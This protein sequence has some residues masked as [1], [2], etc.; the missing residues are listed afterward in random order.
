MIRYK[1][2]RHKQEKKHEKWAARKRERDEQLT[3][4][5]EV[6]PEEPDP[7]AEAEIGLWGLV[8]FLLSTIAIVMLTGKFVTGSYI[9]E[10]DG[11]WVQAKTYSQ[12]RNVTPRHAPLLHHTRGIAKTCL[13]L[14]G[15]VRPIG[16]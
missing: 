6:G 15:P 11:K 5:E 10:Y 13:F 7:T 4:G 16:H 2:Y 9:W 14:A 8:K 12:V 1:E 3:R